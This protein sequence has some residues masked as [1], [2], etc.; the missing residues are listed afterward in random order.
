MLAAM[1]SGITRQETAHPASFP[2]IHLKTCCYYLLLATKLLLYAAGDVATFSADD[3]RPL[4][5]VKGAHMVF[6]TA[7][8]FSQDEQSLL[9]VSA[10]ASALAT[11]VFKMPTS[12]SFQLYFILAVIA[13]ILAVVC[14]FTLSNGVM[15]KPSVVLSQQGGNL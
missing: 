5:R 14:A 4:Q 11:R 13:C 9:T 2:T 12:P 3:L 1:S 7:L 10:D 8:V 6:T 15:A